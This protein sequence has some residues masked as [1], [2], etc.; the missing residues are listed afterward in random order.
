MYSIYCHKLLVLMTFRR[1]AHVK[2]DFDP[3]SMFAA[4]EEVSA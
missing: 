2:E 3:A 4:A 1:G